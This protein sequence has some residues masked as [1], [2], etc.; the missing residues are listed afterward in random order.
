MKS[1]LDWT[2]LTLV[3]K[4]DGTSSISLYINGDLIAIDR[5]QVA[6]DTFPADGRIVLGRAFTDI[7]MPSTQV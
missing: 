5:T 7:G 6:Q 4:N 3:Y 2:H 1:L